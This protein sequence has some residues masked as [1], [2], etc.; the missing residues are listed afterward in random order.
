MTQICHCGTQQSY[1]HA[2][3]CPYPLFSDAPALVG[4]W[5]AARIKTNLIRDC[6]TVSSGTIAQLT[7]R[8][9]YSETDDIQRAWLRW[10]DSLDAPTYKNWQEAWIAWV[11]AREAAQREAAA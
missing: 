10:I 7:G 9:R 11:A 4:E 6:A 1:P 2:P 8:T 3:D 5:T